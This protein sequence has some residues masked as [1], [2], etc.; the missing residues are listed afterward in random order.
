MPVQQW[1]HAVLRVEIV[2]VSMTEWNWKAT[3]WVADREIYSKNLSTMY[4]SVPLADLGRQGWE[5][6]SAFP[7]NAVISHSVRGWTG[8][9]DASMPI[10][11]VFFFKRPL[12]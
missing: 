8:S 12:S 1:E 5:L 11:M 9:R 7:D 6:V 2:S 4:W 10:V 3:A